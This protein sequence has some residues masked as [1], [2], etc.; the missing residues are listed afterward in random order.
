MTNPNNNKK[1]NKKNKTSPIRLQKYLSEQNILSRRKAEEFIKKGYISCNGKPVSILGTKIDP[2]KD[3]ITLSKTAINELKRATTI[4]FN[5]PIGIITNCPQNNEREIRDLLPK[6]LQ[7]LSSIGRLDKDS[8]GL[9]LLTNDSVLSKKALSK[10]HEKIYIVKTKKQITKDQ[11]NVLQSGLIILGKKTLPISINALKENTLEWR[12]H[13][14][15]NRQIRRMI[16]QIGHHVI[17]L[18]RIAFGPIQLS[19]LKKG[20]FRKLKTSEINLF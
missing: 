9:I 19:R 5:K 10:R 6:N 8:H 13:E 4:A 7:N 3:K 14:G 18:K 12:M 17:D 20:Q 1:T 2:S 16:E 15:K 11:L